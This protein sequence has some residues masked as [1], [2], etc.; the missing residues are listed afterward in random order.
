MQFLSSESLTLKE[1][2]ALTTVMG[3][4]FEIARVMCFGS[5]DIA[6]IALISHAPPTLLHCLNSTLPATSKSN[7]GKQDDKSYSCV[8]LPKCLL[9]R[10]DQLRTIQTTGKQ[11][12]RKPIQKLETFTVSSPP[13]QDVAW[14]ASGSLLW[15]QHK[16]NPAPTCLPSSPNADLLYGHELLVLAGKG[17]S[18]TGSGGCVHLSEERRGDTCL[19]SVPSTNEPSSDFHSSEEKAFVTS[20]VAEMVESKLLVKSVIFPSA[21]LGR[22]CRVDF[23]DLAFK[24]FYHFSYCF[25]KDATIFSVPMVVPDLSAMISTRSWR[26]LLSMAVFSWS[27]AILPSTVLISGLY[28]SGFE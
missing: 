13:A 9:P 19:L 6:D 10:F 4:N 24:S 11:I 14:F 28:P 26:L 25:C 22:S 18:T 15:L 20:K 5:C 23:T 8:A 17:S 16:A 7:V 27:S 3:S 12:F 1:N 21:R 2:D